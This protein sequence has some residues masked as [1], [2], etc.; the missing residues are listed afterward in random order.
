MSLKAARTGKELYDRIAGMDA[1][2][3]A[4]HNGCV[5]MAKHA[6]FSRAITL[7]LFIT[8]DRQKRRDS[9][10]EMFLKLSGYHINTILLYFSFVIISTL[11]AFL[12][13]AKIKIGSLGNP[14]RKIHIV[15]FLMSYLFL[16]FFAVF[17]NI[18]T[19]KTAY[20]YF[21]DISEIGNI[22]SGF[23][24]G[25]QMVIAFVKLFTSDSR[26]FICLLSFL[27]VTFY[28]IGIW[29]SRMY[30]SAGLAVF[31]Y[32]S[33]YYLQ[34]Y[35]LMRMY[36]AASIAFAFIDLLYKKKYFKFGIV[37]LI[38]SAIHYSM[39]FSFMAFLAGWLLKAKNAYCVAI[40]DKTLLLT[41]PVFIMSFFGYN[42]L[43]FLSRFSLPVIT[44]YLD[45][46]ARSGRFAF[47]FKWIFNIFPYL[48]VLSL[49]KYD[50]E[51]EDIASVNA[52]YFLMVLAIS[53]MSYRIEMIGR[54]LS[55]MSIPAVLMLPRVLQECKEKTEGKKAGIQ[56]FHVTIRVRYQFI[57]MITV[58]YMVF[59][60]LLYLS[61][62]LYAD[63]I[64]EFRFMWTK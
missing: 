36:F 3:T 22:Y 12:S 41:V 54:A 50:R 21:F 28:Y 30:I 10:Q 24:P 6:S 42:L 39:I 25:F 17:N 58:I 26:V 31:I 13:Q 5:G 18:G 53:V 57:R 40:K 4:E 8:K 20:A 16:T 29:K 64:E 33:Q 63:G 47:G 2:R 45:Y 46:I 55:V 52:G 32:A 7:Y 9:I 48:L 51:K 62:Y 44:K 38:S 23:E 43:V 35:N 59:A 60:F 37:L 27:T 34:Q 49:S 56:I 61:S 1:V 19:D 14:H 11:T 15:P